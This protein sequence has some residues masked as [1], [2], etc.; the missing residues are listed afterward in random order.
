MH[1]GLLWYPVPVYARMPDFI[2]GYWI[3]VLKI[4]GYPAKMQTQLYWFYQLLEIC[5]KM[6]WQQTTTGM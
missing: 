1:P 4:A 2:W 5:F 3:P 6:F